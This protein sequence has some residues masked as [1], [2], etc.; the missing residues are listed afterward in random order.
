MKSVFSK[1][2]VIC[3]MSVGYVLYSLLPFVG[4]AIGDSLGEY[5]EIFRYS[6]ILWPYPLI[7]SLQSWIDMSSRTLLLF[8]PL[9]LVLVIIYGHYFQK[10][11]KISG[12]GK[13]HLHVWFI[14]MWPIPLIVLQIIS[15]AFVWF[16]LGLP[17]GE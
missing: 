7:L 1:Y 9:G 13:W 8:Y 6:M 17:V 10:V 11:F 12:D 14:L 2:P 4:M 16:V 3:W 5:G 15:A